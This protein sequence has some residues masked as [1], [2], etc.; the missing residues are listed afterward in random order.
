MRGGTSKEAGGAVN[1]SISCDALASRVSDTNLLDRIALGILLSQASHETEKIDG[2]RR[3]K[4]HCKT[5][6]VS[7]F[8]YNVCMKTHSI[9][10]P[11]WDHLAVFPA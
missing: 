4:R 11:R 7:N 9:R 8:M 1:A 3:V 5:V 2:Q 6:S 10:L